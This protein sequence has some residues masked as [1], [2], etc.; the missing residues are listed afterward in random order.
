MDFFH[1]RDSDSLREAFAE[2]PGET[3]FTIYSIYALTGDSETLKILEP[4]HLTEEHFKEC[5]NRCK[6]ASGILE[7]PDDN[8][9]QW[10]QRLETEFLRP[11]PLG[12]AAT[13]NLLYIR[14]GT[15]EDGL[16]DMMFETL[17][18]IITLFGIEPSFIHPLWR[19]TDVW[20]SVWRSKGKASFLLVIQKL[21]AMACAFSSKERETTLIVFGGDATP[22]LKLWD[23]N[24]RETD[25]NFY[26]PKWYRD[27]SIGQSEEKLY[28]SKPT[29]PPMLERL[30]PHHLYHPLSFAYM[31]FIDDL[32]SLEIRSDAQVAFIGDLEEEKKEKADTDEADT[33]KADK[34]KADTGKAD[35][36]LETLIRSSQKARDSI[37]EMERLFRGLDIA[38]MVLETM[39]NEHKSGKWCIPSATADTKNRSEEAPSWLGEALPACRQRLKAQKI[40][41]Q[42]QDKRAKGLTQMVSLSAFELS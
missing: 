10:R 1:R 27:G 37:A 18:D 34:N 19:N 31:G 36:G 14:P 4:R 22:D 8:Y 13:L 2:E 23:E 3:T 26:N 38:S 35:T 28:H 24:Y 40:Q 6:N 17:K 5:I 41:L 21:Y 29:E 39:E 33:G 11:K 20:H 42:S 16:K 25:Y 32:F 12:T 15:E 7:G 9:Q 30:R